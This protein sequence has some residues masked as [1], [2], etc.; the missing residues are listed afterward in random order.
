MTSP[1]LVRAEVRGITGTAAATHAA[2]ALSESI[3]ELPDAQSSRALGACSRQVPPVD[4]AAIEPA[5][6]KSWILDLDM[7]SAAPM[8]FAVERVLTEAQRFAERIYTVFRWAVSDDFLRRYGGT[9]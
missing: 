7:F 8:P 4:P 1:R 3:F 5:S 6:E 2:L 9:P